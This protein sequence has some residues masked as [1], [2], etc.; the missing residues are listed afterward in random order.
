MSI[1]HRFC[2]EKRWDCCCCPECDRERF[3]LRAALEAQ[4]AFRPAPV[5]NAMYALPRHLAILEQDGRGTQADVIGYLFRSLCAHMDAIREAGNRLRFHLSGWWH[6]ATAGDLRVIAAWDALQQSEPDAPEAMGALAPIPGHGPSGVIRR[7]E[8]S[9]MDADEAADALTASGSEEEEKV[10]LHGCEDCR[11]YHESGHR[12]AALVID[13]SM[14]VRAPR[15]HF[16]EE[17][18]S[19]DDD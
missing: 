6:V 2:T 5:A 15:F 3:A 12:K 10:H 1:D 18:F 13:P 8:G 11:H 7:D 4:G 9:R 16:D 14:S 17:D 19:H